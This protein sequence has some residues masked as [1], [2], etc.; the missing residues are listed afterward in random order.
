[1]LLSNDT[2]A[3]AQISVHL[4]D[5]RL[6]CSLDDDGDELLGIWQAAL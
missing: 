3:L 5:D 1:M 4:L 2:N 6:L